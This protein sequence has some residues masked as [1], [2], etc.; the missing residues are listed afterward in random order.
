MSLISII[1]LTVYYAFRELVRNKLHQ[2]Q[3]LAGNMDI[4]LSKLNSTISIVNM[5][6][7]SILAPFS[8]SSDDKIQIISLPLIWVHQIFI[9]NLSLLITCIA[10]RNCPF[11]HKCCF[12]DSVSSLLTLMD[13][14]SL[15][16]QT[17][18][19]SIQS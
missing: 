15:S 3:I 11:E 4:F 19:Q 7:A 17:N 2:Q 5:M 10:Q 9:V 18:V 13:L 1:F 14:T 6:S 12:N 8:R 16:S